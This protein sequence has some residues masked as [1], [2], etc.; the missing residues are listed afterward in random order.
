MS[1]TSL[2]SY[3]RT[4]PDPTR[5]PDVDQLTLPGHMEPPVTEG[6]PE[7]PVSDRGSEHDPS[8][9]QSPDGSRLRFRW[10]PKQIALTAAILVAIGVLAW[11]NRNAIDLAAWRAELRPL[12]VVLSLIGSTL[13]LVGAALNLMGASPIRLPFGWTLAVQAAGTPARLVSPA[14]LGGAAVNVHYLRRSGL[15][16]VASVGAVTLAQAI[17]LLGSLAL[18]PVMAVITR[19]HLPFELPSWTLL[20]CLAGGVVAATVTALVISYRY[21]TLAARIRRM[22]AELTKSLRQL[23]RR[24]SQALISAAGAILISLGLTGALWASVH[25]FGGELSLPLAAFVLLFGSTAG[26]VV[27]VPGGLGTVDAAL[28]AALTASGVALADALPA[29]VLFRLVTLWLQLPV[30]IA[31]FG[32]LHRRRLL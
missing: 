32:V 18:L 2:P 13:I 11:V 15:S 14:A 5:E 26:N 22:A 27:P 9:E 4:R 25:A 12:W 24:P 1:T 21:P 20:A 23:G 17:Q 31:C 16:G 6:S 19:H 3:P 10:R 30:G 28:T 8:D 29:V 7:P